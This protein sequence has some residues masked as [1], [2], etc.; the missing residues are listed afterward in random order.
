MT[1][2]TTPGEVDAAIDSATVAHAIGKAGG[3]DGYVVDGVDLAGGFSVMDTTN[4]NGFE[5]V[6]DSGLDITFDGG[7][8]FIWG[9]LARDTQTTVTLP[10]SSTVTISAGFDISATL[11]AGESPADSENIIIGQDSAFADADPRV[12]IYEVTTNSSS[13]TD[14]TSVRPLGR[15]EASAPWAQTDPYEHPSTLPGPITFEGGFGE[16]ITLS[17]SGVGD[18]DISP[19]TRDGGG[20]LFTRNADDPTFQ[21]ADNGQL[22]TDDGDHFAKSDEPLD[23]RI[24]T[25][26]PAEYD[27]WFE[28]S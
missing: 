11:S 22:I 15:A 12:P 14:A 17:R 26:E 24:G 18:W 2:L 23:I 13:V 21:M 1:D 20:L 28:V 9:W 16:H 8:A 6:S 5:H 10:A 27:I 3:H 19:T 25:T 7:E 4:I